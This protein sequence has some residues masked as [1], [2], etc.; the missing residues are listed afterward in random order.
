[1]QTGSLGNIV[2]SVNSDKIE[3]FNNLTWGSSAVIGSHQL[4]LGGNLAEFTGYNADTISFNI[5]ISKYL[6][7]DPDED[8]QKLLEFEKSGRALKL[9]IGRNVYKHRWLIKS[10]KIT[11][12]HYDKLG[13]II[14]ADVAV[15]LTEYLKE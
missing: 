3:T 5:R 1:M 11:A 8:I 15:S 12:K 2:F 14:D 4:H 7:C 10:L 13:N 6:G 9:V